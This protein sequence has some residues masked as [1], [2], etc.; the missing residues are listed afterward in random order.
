MKY[1]FILLL[2]G[3]TSLLPAF[4][5]DSIKYS[6]LLIG[7][8]GEINKD[9]KAVLNDAIKRASPGKTVALFLGDNIYRRGMALDGDDVA[10]TQEILRSQYAPFRTAGLPVFFIPGNHDWDHSG[11]KGFEKMTRVNQF[12][13]D[14]QDSLLQLIPQDVCPGPY[15]V[16]IG[17][18][19]V[20][21]AIDSEWWLFPFEKN[22]EISE[23]ECK[24]KADV[25]GKLQDIVDRNRNKLIFFASH[26]PFRT[27]GSHGGYYSVKEH[28]FPFTDLN[29][30]LY[31]PLPIIGSLYPI[32]R[33]SFP[34]AQDLK[35][36]FYRELIEGVEGVLKNHPN[37]VH[38]AGH[39]HT[40]Q[41]IQGALLE[42]VS[43]AGCKNT[44]VRYGK[45]TR[46]A[47]SE[48]GYVKADVLIDNSIRLS[49]FT[50]KGDEVKQ[51]FTYWKPYTQP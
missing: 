17:D 21:I 48:S 3:L 33:K 1:A 20:L 46:Y 23:C 34:P 6:I 29:K 15:E 45:E 36:V 37:V 10:E 44:P 22:L 30:N 27:H 28:V 26:H 32:L 35:N 7:D 31:I 2:T 5:Q 12:V 19:I 51:T 24:T 42:V 16:K 18:D 9:Q 13:K 41:L 38:V 47:E 50:L 43:G 4:A 40:L 8:A 14:Q 25:L 11:G 49:F 39:E